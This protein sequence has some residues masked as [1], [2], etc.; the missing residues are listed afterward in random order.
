LITAGLTLSREDSSSMT[1]DDPFL[2]T[3]RE[4]PDDMGP[5]LVY[6]DWLEERGDCDRAELIRLQCR[7]KDE[8][9]ALELVHLHG[10]T[11]AGAAARH[12]YGVAFRR[13]FVEEITVCAR[14][15]L[16]YADEIFAA[17]PVRLLRVIGV[18]G[19]LD[20][21][22]RCPN[23]AR[24][25]ALHLTGAGLADAGAAA[26][27]GCEHLANLCTLR[28]GQNAIGDEGV[29]ALADSPWLG[30]IETLVFGGNLIG[31]AGAIALATSRSL[32]RLRVLD[33]SENPISDAGA[34]ALAASFTLPSLKRL[35]LAQRREW[36]ATRA[37]RGE[38][39]IQ[40][41]QR[42]ALVA[43]FGADVCVF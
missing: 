19:V 2:L 25:E 28:L 30:K 42:A 24:V 34:E 13:G 32:G 15:L 33:L 3:I 22:V 16:E 35:D 18:A 7:D 6:A 11:W 43:K 14:T 41:K 5:R 8:G 39:P 38:R 4:H 1:A 21:F 17:A 12:A 36:A 10:E 37:L 29:E 23:L 40:Q 27:A 20:G 9:R 31:D 26:L